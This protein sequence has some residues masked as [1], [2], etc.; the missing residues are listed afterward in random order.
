M[1]A[2]PDLF[3][4]SSIREQQ[5]TSQSIDLQS[6]TKMR[7]QQ[8]QKYTRNTAKSTNNITTVTPTILQ[9]EKKYDSPDCEG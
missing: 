5:L 7:R 1:G 4:R 8:L 3:Q 6:E 9:K 2:E